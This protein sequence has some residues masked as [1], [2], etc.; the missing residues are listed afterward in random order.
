MQKQF[1]GDECLSNREGEL[2]IEG[3]AATKLV[4]QF[5][6]PLFIV[7]ENQIR[8]NVRRFQKAF[9]VGWTAGEVKVLPAVKAN[10]NLA[11]QKV[12]ASEDCGADV[13]SAGELEIALR[14]GFDPKF[15]SVNGVPKTRQH[16][17]RTLQ[18]GARLTIDSLEDVRILEEIHHELTTTAYVR[19]RLRPATGHTQATDFMAEG[20]MPTDIAAL[21]YKSGLSVDEV[22]AAGQR[23][24]KLA[25]VEIVG[26]HQHHGRHRSSTSWWRD[27]MSSYAR[28]I[29]RVVHTL[30]IK[31]ILEI[32]I[33]G[34]YAIPRDPHAKAIDRSA[35]VL[36]GALYLLSKFLKVFGD[37]RRVQIISLLTGMMT[38]KPNQVLAPTI[39]DYAAVITSTLMHGLKQHGVDPTGIMLQLEPGRGI[40]GNSGV[41]LSTICSIK[42]QQAPLKWNVVTLDTSEFFLSAG[43]FEHHMHDYRVV[44][45]LDRPNAMVADV[46][47]RSCYADRLLGAV[48]LPDV[49]VGDI[50][51]MLDTGAYQE[52]SCS[53]FNAMPRPA[54]VMVTG[55][56]ATLIKR[57]ETIDDVLAREVVPEHLMQLAQTQV[58]RQI[59][60]ESAD[61]F[62][63]HQ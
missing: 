6:S 26:F 2:F 51:A 39:E 34:G 62:L 5:G 60:L 63:G 14:A 46:T 28:D 37:K 10:W 36:Y 52:V 9:A 13:Y 24:A 12:L 15:I 47:G 8:R 18:V 19:L 30:K 55:D 23:L 44:S 17:L 42:R 49:E 48:Q 20:P 29:A 56:R 45:K 57:A 35:P 21:G 31:R 50:F 22:L 4:A 32:D 59:G 33:G 11:V 27:Q 61:V 53:N 1:K 25:R 7:S 16:I 3:M 38:T 54:S 41:Q 40:H 58:E 43:R